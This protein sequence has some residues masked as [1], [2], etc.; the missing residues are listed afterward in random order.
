MFMPGSV[1]RL[2]NIYGTRTEKDPAEESVGVLGPA[3]AVMSSLQAFEAI[4]IL[5][6][7]KPAYADRL[8]YFDGETGAMEIVPLEGSGAEPRAGV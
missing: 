4:R 1:M 5:T 8:L 6:G 7:R 3:P 2:S